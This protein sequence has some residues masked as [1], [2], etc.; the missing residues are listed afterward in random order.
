MEI[1]DEPITERLRRVPLFAHLKEEEFAAIVQGTEIWLRPG[2]YIAHEGDPPSD[3]YVL[4]D[5]Q[6]EWTRR[7]GSQQ[8]Y[9]A[10]NDP[11]DPEPFWGHELILSDTPYPV[12][13]RA[14]TAVHLYKLDPDSFWRMLGVCRLVTRSLLTTAAQRWGNVYAVSQQY[15]RLASLGTLAA[16]LAHELNNPAAA[17]KR[18]VEGLFGSFEASQ[19]LVFRLLEGGVI[20]P[21]CLAEIGCEA[22]ERARA[23]SPLL[24]ALERSDREEEIAAWLEARRMTGAWDMAATLSGAGLDVAWL[25]SLAA[26]APDTV[27]S[28]LL[29]WVAANLTT[30]DL[31]SEVAG[32]TRR[33]SA[34]VTAVKDYSYVDQAPLQ[35]IDIHQGLEST[36]TMLAHKI[37]EGRIT[38]SRDYTADLPRICAYGSELNQVWTNLIDN[39][40]DAVNG[41][42]R[43][44][45][46]TAS[47]SPERVLV[48]IEDN[49]PG[50]PPDAQARIFEPFFTT[51]GV[52]RGTGLGLDI[53][54]RI[55]EERHG[56]DIRFTSA[57]GAGVCFQVRLPLVVPQR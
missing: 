13:G 3:F 27:L 5:G 33:I 23:A 26:R 8:V 18:A 56:G 40:I 19:S 10:T 39:A 42:G 50:I 34:L 44:T 36:L 48:E 43:I 7:V 53:S 41:S 47:E 24:S 21:K 38:V 46:R 29:P 9:V 37:R 4:L 1:K 55:I 49:G 30:S 28:D 2:E 22:R 15:A 45:L 16:G 6:V 20:S 52:G 35:E 54:R 31:L 11:A 57:P 14:L 12:S 51:K 32:S 25:E 17:A